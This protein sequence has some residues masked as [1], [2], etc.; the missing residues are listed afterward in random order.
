M[1]T[2]VLW[3]V[4]YLMIGAVIREILCETTWDSGQPVPVLLFWPLFVGLGIIALAGWGC[5]WAL[6]TWAKIV[7]SGVAGDIRRWGTPSSSSCGD[8]SCG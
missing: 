5:Y 4:V 2:C 3:G 7:V 1:M 8:D 6:T